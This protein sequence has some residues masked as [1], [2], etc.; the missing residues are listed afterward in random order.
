M[1]VPE[2]AIYKDCH[3]TL[4]EDDI[5]SARECPNVNS[6]PVAEGV[7]DASNG[8]F[9]PGVLSPYAGHVPAAFLGT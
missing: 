4:V 5:R 8:K 7:Q 2:A 6:V 1:L 3:S 9:G